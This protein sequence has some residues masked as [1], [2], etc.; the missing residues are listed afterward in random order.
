MLPTSDAYWKFA[1]T[2]GFEEL[3]FVK[4]RSFNF[5]PW[6]TRMLYRGR[7]RFNKDIQENL[8]LAY[9]MGLFRVKNKETCLLHNNNNIQA[10]V[11]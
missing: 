9:S 3:K 2:V 5:K 11:S 10:W 8:Y 7:Y 4:Y 6:S 1:G